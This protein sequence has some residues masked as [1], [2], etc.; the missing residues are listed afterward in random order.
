MFWMQRLNSRKSF[1]SSPPLA[2]HVD[3]SEG[4]RDLN[5]LIPV[6]PVQPVYRL[7]R[8]KKLVN[9]FLQSQYCAEVNAEISEGVAT[10]SLETQRS[11]E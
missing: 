9:K 8:D 10:N 7:I 2:F 3:S 4:K 5:S 6:S 11:L 1:G